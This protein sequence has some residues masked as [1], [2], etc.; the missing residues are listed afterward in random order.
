[1]REHAAV[2]ERLRRLAERIDERVVPRAAVADPLRDALEA[3]ARAV[4][5]RQQRAGARR[6]RPVALIAA[7]Q[8]SSVNTSR[9][10]IAAALA[11]SPSNQTATKPGRS[12]RASSASGSVAA[13]SSSSRVRSRWCA[14]SRSVRSRPAGRPAP[15]GIS[16]PPGGWKWTPLGASSSIARSEA[17]NAPGGIP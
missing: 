5:A 17:A 7:T 11:S 15:P 16:S 14:T 13:T 12:G 4:E 6:G 3:G 8:T 2:G 1:M 10:A 9:S